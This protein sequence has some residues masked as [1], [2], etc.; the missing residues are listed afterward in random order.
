M[1]KGTIRGWIELAIYPWSVKADGSYEKFR[2]GNCNRKGRWEK[3]LDSIGTLQQTVNK[4][5]I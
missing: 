5:Q 1:G 3:V 2:A 4:F